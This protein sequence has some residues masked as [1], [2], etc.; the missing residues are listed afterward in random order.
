[1]I[2]T[3][4]SNSTSAQKILIP[5]RDNTNANEF[6]LEGFSRFKLVSAHDPSF[7]YQ[8]RANSPAVLANDSGSVLETTITSHESNCIADPLTSTMCAPVD[9]TFLKAA[10]SSS[11]K[12]ALNC[13]GSSINRMAGYRNH[14][15][16]S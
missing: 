5:I 11:L 12:C 2:M 10:T 13:P 6:V 8:S 9:T 7:Q 15:R 16:I 14:P 3:S 4:I 1:M